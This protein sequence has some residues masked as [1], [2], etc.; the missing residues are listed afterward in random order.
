MA[1]S[2]VWFITG[3]SSGF[4]EAFARHAL[5]QGYRV[6]AT[7]RDTGKL[8]ALVAL[9]PER[10]LALPLDVTREGAAEAAVA[11]AVERFGRIDVLV[12]N[13]GVTRHV[14]AADL[15]AL[16][17]TDFDRVFAVNLS[18][19]RPKGRPADN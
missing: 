11:V 8:A 18:G 16:T 3:A 12:N 14:P 5:A 19:A 6:V 4:G 1:T 7:A 17:A 15:E 13:A 10:V 2:Q 9:A